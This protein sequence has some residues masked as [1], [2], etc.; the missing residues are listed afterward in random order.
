MDVLGEFA[1]LGIVWYC[2]SSNMG[3]RAT[4]RGLVWFCFSGL[5]VGPVGQRFRVHIPDFVWAFS[6]SRHIPLASERYLVRY[7][8]PNLVWLAH[9]AIVFRPR[10]CIIT[11]CFLGLLSARGITT[12]SGFAFVRSYLSLITWG[13][14]GGGGGCTL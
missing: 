9:P 3:L 14:G 6:T 11:F 12:C 2:S 13:C 4:T 1:P 5:L 10:A 7:Y 8:L